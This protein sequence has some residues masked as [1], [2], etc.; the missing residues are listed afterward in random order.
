MFN[1]NSFACAF[2]LDSLERNETDL[3]GILASASIVSACPVAIAMRTICSDKVLAILLSNSVPVDA[4]TDL[5]VAKSLALASVMYL[6]TN[7]SKTLPIL[8][9]S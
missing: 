1:D 3:A 4:N 8:F 2:R 9:L 5:I 7:A 6:P